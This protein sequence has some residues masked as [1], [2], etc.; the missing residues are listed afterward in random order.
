MEAVNLTSSTAR[1][2]GP[3]HAARA[4]RV[5]DIPAAAGAPC[6]SCS[7]RGATLWA[8]LPNPDPDEDGRT[9]GGSGLSFPKAKR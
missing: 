9:C 4:T 5:D 8:I 6:V 2:Y 3:P 7:A 1:S